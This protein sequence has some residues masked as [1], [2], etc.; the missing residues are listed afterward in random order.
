MQARTRAAPVFVL[1]SS[2]ADAEMALQL[3][4]MHLAASP[5][6]MERASWEV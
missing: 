5:E 2:G 1:E 6:L 4:H 3:Q